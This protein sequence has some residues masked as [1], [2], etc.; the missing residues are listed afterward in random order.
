M[1]KLPHTVVLENLERSLEAQ[2]P[3]MQVVREAGWCFASLEGLENVPGPDLMVLP[4]EDYD[5][6]ARSG[7]YFEGRPVFVVEVVSPAERKSRRVQKLG[8]NLEAGL[9]AVLAVDYARRSVFVY[10]PDQDIV[11]EVIRER[12]GCAF[13][14]ELSDIFERILP[15]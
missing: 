12:V 9:G 7:G 8:L 5:N 15:S 3:E 11:P 13:T 6:A 4:R 1:P 10:R 14:A 2:S